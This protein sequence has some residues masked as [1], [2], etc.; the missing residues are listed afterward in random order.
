MHWS[1]QMAARVNCETWATGTTRD[2]QFSFA[3]VLAWASLHEPVYP[4]APH[5]H[6]RP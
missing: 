4:G 2:R 1:V 5:V 3:E 6:G